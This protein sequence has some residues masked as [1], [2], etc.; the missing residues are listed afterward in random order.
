MADWNP[1][2]L[3]DFI[4]ARTTYLKP[5]KSL[6]TDS[7]TTEDIFYEQ[8]SHYKKLFD[9]LFNTYGGIMIPKG[10]VLFHSNQY[11]TEFINKYEPI[12]TQ[13]KI[14]DIRTYKSKKV[15]GSFF[16]VPLRN[17]YSRLY[18]NFTPY[19]NY[20]VVA[21]INASEHIYKLTEDMYF[22][23]IP[24][25]KHGFIKDIFQLS[26]TRYLN[27]YMEERNE[28]DGKDTKQVK[29]CGWILSTSVDR[30]KLNDTNATRIPIGNE[31]IY[32]EI[33]LLDGF[34]KFIKIGQ[35]DI[36]DVNKDIPV[37]PRNPETGLAA[38][39]WNPMKYKP[40]DTTEEF[41]VRLS[42]F[43]RDD[44]LSILKHSLDSNVVVRN[45]E[46][47][48]PRRIFTFINE[49]HC[50]VKTLSSRYSDYPLNV[51]HIDD[52]D[53]NQPL[54]FNI[55]KEKDLNLL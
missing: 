13:M 4:N 30:S 51:Y 3:D 43:V 15:G 18:C 21:N 29:W 6:I 22:L 27:Q 25:T 35:C 34:N 5:I 50:S 36:L 39:Q 8:Y 28:I 31:Y 48:I 20:Y 37:D 17:T 19:A 1:Q 49:L 41:I 12:G 16:K 2:T 10:T 11:F 32:P 26:S 38:Q 46:P 54:V 40:H 23:Q 45:Y 44:S 24:W 9:F 47:L 53:N 33:L 42:D 55:F 7:D 52:S 14:Q